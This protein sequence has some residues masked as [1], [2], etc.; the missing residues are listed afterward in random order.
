SSAPAWKDATGEADYC[1]GLSGVK[2]QC[3]ESLQGLIAA[4]ALPASD[5]FLMARECPA[6]QG[7]RNAAFAD[8]LNSR[9]VDRRCCY[10]GVGQFVAYQG[11]DRSDEFRIS[12]RMNA[13]RNHGSH[14]DFLQ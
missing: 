13:V 11:V 12:V 1:C 3:G 5:G 10:P 14:D 2:A 8:E 9:H 7:V 6:K 4:S